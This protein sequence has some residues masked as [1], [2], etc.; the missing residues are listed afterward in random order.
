LGATVGGAGAATSIPG[1]DPYLITAAWAP[2]A[3]VDL[4]WLS[5]IVVLN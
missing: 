1:D 2:S 5:G 4:A 3:T